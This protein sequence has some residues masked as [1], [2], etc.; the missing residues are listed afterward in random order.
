MEVNCDLHCHSSYAGGT[1]SL[2]LLKTDETMP[3]KGISLL[4][5]GD[6]QYRPWNEFL[7]QTLK[8]TPDSG[9]YELK[10]GSK[11]KFVLQTEL[12]FTAKIQKKSK[13]AHVIFLFPN[14]DVLDEFIDVL[15]EK[16]GCKNMGRPF[17]KCP[18]S[19][20]VGNKINM[21]LDLDT[22]VECIPAHVLTPSGV[23][24]SNTRINFLEDFFANSSDRIKCV[25]TGLS[26]DPIILSLIPELE[27]RTWISNSDAHSPALNRLGREFTTFDFGNELSYPNL[28][29]AIRRNR[30]VRTAE[31][32][33]SEGRY[34]LTGHRDVKWVPK[35]EETRK[36]RKS[37][38]W[39]DKGE[40]CYYSP[41]LVPKDEKCPICGK[42]LT[43]GVLQRA[44]EINRTQNGTRKLGDLIPNSPHFIHMV[45]LVEVIAYAYGIKSPM[46]QKVVTT[47]N[48]ILQKLDVTECDFWFIKNEQ[49]TEELKEEKLVN[50]LLE[51]KNSNFRFEPLGFDG[52]YGKLVV[53]KKHTFQDFLGISVI[54]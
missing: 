39:H 40:F 19:E 34:F 22:N 47:Y 50:T 15:E 49:I 13:L 41:D 27:G 4:G 38:N 26:A 42:R 21:I 36:K 54:S 12:V 52:T 10:Q 31:F 16:W 51:V 48:E 45:P 35:D 30:V 37:K 20:E 43:L 33:P 6:C 9:I 8:E 5:T 18:T 2:D 29:D 23:F 17:V 44:I 7:K 1:G 3:L 11:T 24:G 25:E 32:L 28:I 14:F 53:G 46:A